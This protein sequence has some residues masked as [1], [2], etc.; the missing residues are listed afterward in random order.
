MSLPNY[1]TEKHILRVPSDVMPM[2]TALPIDGINAMHSKVNTAPQCWG[3][4]AADAARN[5]G[6][7]HLGADSTLLCW[8]WLAA[9]IQQRHNIFHRGMEIWCIDPNPSDRTFAARL[10]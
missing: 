7:K 9:A 5:L 4:R 10:N 3:W 8:R 6:A 1:S 2:L